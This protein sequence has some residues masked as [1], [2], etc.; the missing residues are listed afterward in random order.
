MNLTHVNTPIKIG[1]IEVKNRVVRTAH[2]TGLA[3]GKVSDELVTY[4]EERAKGGVG[5][6]ILEVMG[7]HQSGPGALNAFL[8]PGYDDN[9]PRMMDRLHKYD[10][11]VFQQLWHAGNN[12]LP[13]DGS[14]PWAPSDIPGPLLNV[15]P[16][17][18]TKAMIDEI[19]EA[20]AEAT[21]RCEQWGLDGVEVHC[22]HGYLPSQFLSRNTNKRTDDYGGPIENRARFMLE[23]LAAC[24]AVVS[25]DFVVGIRLSADVIADGVDAS[26]NL[27]VA[28]M[29]EDR[30]LIDFVNV[31]QGVYQSFPKFIGGM[32]EP[33]GYELD[34]SLPVTQNLKN[35]PTMVIGR[36]RTLEEADQ[37]IRNGDCDMVGMNRAT[38]AD[39]HLVRKTFEGHPEQVRPCIA[40]NQGCI[41]QELQLGHIGCAV[42]TGAGDESN[43][44][45]HRLEVSETPKRVL[46]IGG[47]PAGMEAARVAALRGH[48]VVL[49]EAQPDLGGTINIAAKA[50]TRQ[51]LRD[52]TLWLEQELYRLGVEVRLSTYLEVDDIAEQDFD[53]V[54]VATGATPRMDGIQISNPGEPVRGI[55]QD[56][57]ISSNELFE[58][59]RRELGRTAVVLDDTG[60]FEG[61]AAAEYLLSEGLEV[62][63]VSRQIS[64]APR[65]EPALMA[66]PALQRLTNGHFH[67]KLRSRAIEIQKDSVIV[68]PTFVAEGNNVNESVPA[69][70]VVLISLNRPN[71]DLYNQ[72]I[73]RGMKAKVV[74]DAN[75]PRFLTYA[76]REGHV[77]GAT[78]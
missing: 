57:V 16:V 6:T 44:G 15:V 22:A 51:N 61:I 50:P 47:G 30:G 41:G 62:T 29:A 25:K 35:T 10:M 33:M 65:V 64:F 71:R 54:V 43:W 67:N 1:N 40:C 46:V 8:A 31:S 37:L 5:L 63:Y 75:T 78:V 77:A 42:N 72:L 69:D 39:P 60:H 23:L 55:Q 13:L 73:D 26:D 14:P 28:K 2:G 59:N 7:V 18:M 49:A 11:T 36:F 70:T 4:H 52:I 12:I 9:F 38:I 76:M 32:H 27:Q 24:R 45:D 48:K 53:E 68:A 74:G 3:G 58:N 56:H 21:R 66:E 20:Y 17:S 19:V 34:T